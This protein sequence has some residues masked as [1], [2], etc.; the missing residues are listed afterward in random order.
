MKKGVIIL[1]V[2]YMLMGC[3]INSNDIKLEE[4]RI[5]IL[6]L[7]DE[8]K[9]T[10][11][12]VEK[13]Q[14]K[15]NISEEEKSTKG[16]EYTICE[17]QPLES[18]TM[19]LE[20]SNLYSAPSIGAEIVEEN[21]EGLLLVLYEVSTENGKWAYVKLQSKDMS[22]ISPYGFVMS[23]LL[24]YEPPNAVIDPF[25]VTE[26]ISIGM[27]FSEMKLLFRNNYI[28]LKDFYDDSVVFYFDEERYNHE[29]KKYATGTSSRES[30]E[31]ALICKFTFEFQQ[32]S[33]LQITSPH[34]KLISGIGVGD[35]YKEVKTYCDLNYSEY[36]DSTYIFDEEKLLVYQMSE[37]ATVMFGFDEPFGELTYIVINRN[38][39]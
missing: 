3:S 30:L 7:K 33:E 29:V 10:T 37:K 27:T 32:L 35:S 18:K 13:L 39:M 26:D 23:D 21:I 15:V 17:T 12:L 22:G 38:G 6:D 24:S 2:T 19:I 9:N 4:A 14:N 31:N 1:I 36:T 8:M 28:A 20:K 25:A 5:E 34:I 16:I 11:I